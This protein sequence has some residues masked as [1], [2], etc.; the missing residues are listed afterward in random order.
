MKL[1]KVCGLLLAVFVAAVFTAK[2]WFMDYL[3]RPLTTID[4]PVIIDVTAGMS[5]KRLIN[6][7]ANKGVLE[8]PDWV[9]GYVRLTDQ[10]NILVGEYRIDKTDS[11]LS[12]LKKIQRGDVL[13]H[14]V[15]I[16]EGFNLSEMMR[17]LAANSYLRQT[18]TLDALPALISRLG[19]G[20]FDNVEG[21]FFPDSYAIVKGQ[22]ETQLLTVMAQRLQKVLADEWQKRDKDLP[23]KTPY[24]ALIMAS[25]I[26]KETGLESERDEIAGVFVRRLRKNMRLQTDPTVIYGMGERYQGKITRRDLKTDTAYNTYTRS[27]LPPTPIALVGREAIY[28]ALHPKPGKSL[29]FVAKGDGS[30]YFSDTLAEHNKAVK[31]YQLSRR[32]DYRSQPNAKTEK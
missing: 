22:S 32:A 5:Y 30:H 23:Y 28:A 17:R 24:E 19:Y 3:S 11:V 20:D 2:Y 27:G 8:Y 21:L 14:L 29:Y 16:P 26:E 15:T 31:Q 1:L 9:F 7:L 13:S 4:Q 18:T 10:P 12:V 6:E 25:I